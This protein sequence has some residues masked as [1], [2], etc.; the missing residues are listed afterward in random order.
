[1]FDLLKIV[2]EVIDAPGA[3]QL[4]ITGGQVEMKNVVFSYI[5]ERIVLRNISFVVPPGK[6]YA[7]VC[8]IKLSTNHL[9][10]FSVFYNVSIKF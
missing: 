6:T 9:G 2:P 7:L 1:M 8:I 3:P 5:P 4:A 10:L